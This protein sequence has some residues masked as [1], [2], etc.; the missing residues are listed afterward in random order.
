MSNREWIWAIFAAIVS[1]IALRR[2][3]LLVSYLAD[4]I[5]E[6]RL[7]RSSMRLPDHPLATISADVSDLSFTIKGLS[8]NVS[9]LREDVEQIRYRPFAV[10][11]EAGEAETCARS[12]D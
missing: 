11:Q 9:V 1:G 6:V 7:L 12:T 5:Q 10:G 8:D 3:S 2:L 4:L